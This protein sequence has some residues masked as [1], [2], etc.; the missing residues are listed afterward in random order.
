MSRPGAFDAPDV[1]PC[2][3]PAVAY[4]HAPGH[5]RFPAGSRARCPPADRRVRSTTVAASLRNRMGDE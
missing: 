4:P 3:D 1:V 2:V 5:T